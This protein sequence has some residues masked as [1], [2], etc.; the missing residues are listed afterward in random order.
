L[1]TSK[2]ASA[3]ST[4]FQT[5]IAA[6]SMGLARLSFTLSFAVS[7]F[8]TRSEMRRLVRNGFAYQKP[9]VLTVPL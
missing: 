6:I 2:S 1:S 5:T 9:A 7:K 8:R 3:V 4:T